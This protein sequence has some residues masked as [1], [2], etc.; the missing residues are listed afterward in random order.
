MSVAADEMIEWGDECLECGAGNVGEDGCDSCRLYHGLLN[1]NLKGVR[2]FL[3]NNKIKGYIA[4]RDI[5]TRLK[6]DGYI[7]VPTQ[8]LDAD[9]DRLVLNVN[10]IQRLLIG[11]PKEKEILQ[12]LSK[13][14]KGLPDFICSSSYGSE[15]FFVEVK[16]N[17]SSVSENQ[18]EVI[19]ALENAGYKFLVRRVKVEFSASEDKEN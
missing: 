14:D 18:K 11:F 17:G 2:T 12:I 3:S 13:F 16:A 7:V 6:N 4:E 1:L 5:S 8:K 10:E 9:K 15:P 19:K